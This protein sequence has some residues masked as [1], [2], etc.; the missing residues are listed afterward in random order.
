MLTDC[1]LPDCNHC[2]SSTMK[3]RLA[4]A[5]MARIAPRQKQVGEEARGCRQD[6][7]IRQCVCDRRCDIVSTTNR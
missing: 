5:S 6:R 7:E 1:R 4:A 2:N 3:N